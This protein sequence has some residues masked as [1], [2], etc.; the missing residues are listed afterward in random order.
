MHQN[1][2]LTSPWLKKILN[3]WALKRT[4]M[5]DFGQK[6]IQYFT[7]VEE[8][9]KFKSSKPTKCFTM[10]DEKSQFKSSEM[11]KNEGFLGKSRENLD[12]RIYRTENWGKLQDFTGFCV[13]FRTFTCKI[14]MFEFQI[15]RIL[16]DYRTSGS[17]AFLLHQLSTATT[18]KLT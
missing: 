11:H 2:A 13:N 15:Y 5:K 12:H 3:S 1:E 16:Q 18:F 6:H 7:M 17:P 4:R 14:L 10:V 8:N 9:F